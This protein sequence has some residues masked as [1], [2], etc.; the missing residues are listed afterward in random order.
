MAIT[1]GYSFGASELV[2]NTKLSSLVDDAT[3]S[4]IVNA[5]IDASAAIAMSKLE[6]YAA[7]TD[8]SD[9]STITGWSSFTTK[10]IYT[11][12]IGKTVFVEYR[13]SGT[14]NANTASFT[15]PY[16]CVTMADAGFY[17]PIVAI[18]NGTAT[19]NAYDRIDEADFNKV[20]CLYDF[21]ITGWT[22]SGTKVV[23]GRMA[24]E[25]A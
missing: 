7:W 23:F 12:K 16:T 3:I 15:V 19:L 2:T 6:G 9:T 18:N 22:T 21:S 25:S 11:K 8:Y 1:K 24:Y 4:G 17:S 5:E 10:R 20:E 14:S 13:I